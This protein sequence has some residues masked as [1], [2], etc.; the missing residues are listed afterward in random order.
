MKEKIAIWGVFSSLFVSISVVI[1]TPQGSEQARSMAGKSRNGKEVEVIR[2][3]GVV[4]ISQELCQLGL[5]SLCPNVPPLPNPIHPVYLLLPARECVETKGRLNANLPSHSV[6]CGI[7]MNK[8]RH[9]GIICRCYSFSLFLS[10]TS[11]DNSKFA[12]L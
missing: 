11:S 5:H 7:C 6:F 2:S 9:V 3:R 1:K 8:P 10:V 4:P 12:I